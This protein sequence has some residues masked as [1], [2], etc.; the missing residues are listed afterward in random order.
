MNTSNT[1]NEQLEQPKFKTLGKGR[2][3][4]LV[5]VPTTRLHNVLFPGVKDRSRSAAMPPWFWPERA[6]R[7]LPRWID[8]LYAQNSPLKEA[9]Q[10]SGRLWYAECAHLPPGGRWLPEGVASTVQTPSKGLCLLDRRPLPR[11]SKYTLD[12]IEIPHVV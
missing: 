12:E 8:R 6:V 9:T 10:P 3:H 7:G 11:E 2:Y 4:L 1:A 5:K